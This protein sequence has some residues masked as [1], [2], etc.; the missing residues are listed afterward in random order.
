MKWK[1]KIKLYKKNDANIFIFENFKW[2]QQSQSRVASCNEIFVHKYMYVIQCSRYDTLL[3][4]Y[5]YH[6]NNV[7]PYSTCNFSLIYYQMKCYPPPHPEK[8]NNKK[9]RK[10]N[11]IPQRNKIQRRHLNQQF[12]LTLSLLT[13]Q[14]RYVTRAA[15]TMHIHPIG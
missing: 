1:I 14:C 8:S 15:L 4:P 13:L 9:E 5:T 10:R 11:K 2:C 6:L 3:I 12:K 7:N